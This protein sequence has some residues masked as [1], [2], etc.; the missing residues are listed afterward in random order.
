ME[1]D[2]T[3]DNRRSGLGALIGAFIL[4]V[5]SLALVLWIVVGSWGGHAL[6][7]DTASNTSEAGADIASQTSP[8]P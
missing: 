6:F 4:S 3:F 7:A 5:V 1:R 8:A 2:M